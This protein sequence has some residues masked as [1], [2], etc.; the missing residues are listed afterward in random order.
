M[1][2]RTSC[3]GFKS[4]ESPGYSKADVPLISRMCFAALGLIQ[5]ALPCI[6]TYSFCILYWHANGQDLNPVQEVWNIMKKRCESLPNN[7]FGPLWYSVRRNKS[8]N[9]MICQP[10]FRQNTKPEVTPQCFQACL[11]NEGT[12]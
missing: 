4:R 10:A 6:N 8:F 12:H 9:R 1:I 7:K 11:P 2:F 5:R 3:I